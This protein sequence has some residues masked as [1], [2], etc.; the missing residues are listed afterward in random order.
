MAV[1]EDNDYWFKQ[2]GDVV[3]IAREIDK[4]FICTMK[5]HYQ[6][7]RNHGIGYHNCPDKTLNGFAKLDTPKKC[8]ILRFGNIREEKGV[9]IQKELDETRNLKH[10]DRPESN[11]KKHKN[12]LWIFLEWLNEGRMSMDELKVFAQDAFRMKYGKSKVV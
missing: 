2:F 1:Y 4:F 12:E 5:T 11:I 8:L 10:D 3:D 9:Q 7:T 6:K